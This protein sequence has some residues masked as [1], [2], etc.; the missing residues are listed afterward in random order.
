VRAEVEVRL[1]NLQD[2]ERPPYVCPFLDRE[3]G[4]CH[5]Y[6]HRPVACRTY[7][8]YVERGVGSYC[9]IIRERVESGAY[10]D[11]VWG[12][13]E[14]VDERLSRMGGKIPM[15]EWLRRRS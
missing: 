10:A 3:N 6:S 5:I 9:G 11:V 2:G 8:F 1:A 4:A 13:H 12:N 7:G 15:R 14:A